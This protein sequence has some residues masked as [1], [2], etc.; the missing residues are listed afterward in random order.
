MNHSLHKVSVLKI[1][2]VF[3]LAFIL[4][5]VAAY[6][7]LPLLPTD[8]VRFAVE[9]SIVIAVSLFTLR[10]LAKSD[11]SPS[12]IF[13]DTAMSKKM[14][15]FFSA[16]TIGELILYFSFAGLVM[17]FL[18]NQPGFLSDAES[19]INEPAP[20][21]FNGLSIIS[22]V[23][24]APVYE[25]FLFRGI[26]LNKWAEKWSN[27]R[28]LFLSSLLFGLL[29]I[30]AYIIP[31]IIGGLLYGMVYLKTKKLIYPIIMHALSNLL[32]VSIQFIPV[33]APTEV[34]TLSE[35]FIAELTTAL[36]VASLVF[37]I[38]LPVLIVIVYR[39][40]RN[41]NAEVSPI[42]FNAQKRVV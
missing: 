32:L 3:A 21:G 39:Y 38:T 23:I 40:S 19:F 18:I 11:I 1:I 27:T 8:V 25:E 24:L 26:I 36:N 4:S 35:Q 9:V 13:G 41:L 12:M 34:F 31:Q 29:H 28:A 16:L 22:A 30:G 33:D 2:A 17:R 7:M 42:V 15:G 14:I 10:H 5:T 6:F 37:L 20:E